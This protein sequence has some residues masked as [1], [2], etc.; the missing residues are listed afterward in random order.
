[1]GVMVGAFVVL[2]VV[3]PLAELYVVIQVAHVLGAFDTLALLVLVSMV[4]AWLVK[5]EGIGVWRRFQRQVQAGT[6]P[7]REVADGFMILLAGAL[8]LVPGFITDA[9][10]LL[11]LLPPVRA[12]VR[13]AVLRRASRRA[14]IVR[15]EVDGGPRYG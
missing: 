8:L 7:G 2:F 9:L 5:R 14:G 6:V 10:G 11:L 13:T 3:A 4:G 15:Y 12:G 1:M